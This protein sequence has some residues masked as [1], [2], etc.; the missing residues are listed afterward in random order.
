MCTT[1]KAF[2]KEFREDV[3][4]VYRDSE[5]SL[6][7]VAKDSGIWPSCLKQWI[8]IDDRN[9]ATL[10]R[11]AGREQVRRASGGQQANQAARVGERGAASGC[12]LPFPGAPAGK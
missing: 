9:S 5:A 4:R 12:D 7:Q 10:A 1:P 6:V 8:T 11:G 2:S 3:I